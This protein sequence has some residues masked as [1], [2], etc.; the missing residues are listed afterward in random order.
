V[1]ILLGPLGWGIGEARQPAA[2]AAGAPAWPRYARVAARGFAMALP[3]LIVLTALLASA[4]PVFEGLLHAALFTGM[5]PL[6]EHLAFAGA[7]AWFTTGYLRS[8]LVGDGAMER[9]R[10]PRPAVASSEVAVALSLLN[11]LFLLFLAVQVRYLFGG[12]GL[13]EVTAGM[14]YAEY[15]RRGF[16]ELVMASALVVPLLLVAHWAATEEEGRSRRM[17]RATSF[18]LVL[19]LAGVLASAAYRMRLYQH[20]YGLTETRLYGSMFMLWLTGVLAWLAATVIR[21]RR[22]GF[23]FGAVAGGL[24]CIAALHAV[25]PHALIARVN[26]SRAAMGAE[27]DGRYLGT[28]SA[29]AVPTLAA[30]LPV[31]PAEERCR[32]VTMLEERWS[33]QRQ[34]GWRTWNQADAR[35]RSIVARLPASGECAAV[36]MT[37][38]GDR[39]FTP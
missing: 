16:V 26:I 28:L 22:R 1:L 36:A 17:L 4:D 39:I 11:V 27:V 25:N 21:G 12:S 34:G 9:V 23:A 15:A 8:F 29:D 32:V 6:L 3:P 35:A 10:V 38:G 14:G 13:V 24:A 7:V 37:S 18:L 33:G 19:L 30:R 20:A 5:E 2:Q 31:L